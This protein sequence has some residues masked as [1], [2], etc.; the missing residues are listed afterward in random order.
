M[1][2]ERYGAFA[3]MLTGAKRRFTVGEADA[4][5]SPPHP[6]DRSIA[7]RSFAVSSIHGFSIELL[8]EEE[9]PEF[10]RLAFVVAG[11]SW[12]RD[13]SLY[14][15]NSERSHLERPLAATSS[16]SIC[17]RS[18]ET[19]I[20]LARGYQRNIGAMDDV[21]AVSAGRTASPFASQVPILCCWVSLRRPPPSGNSRRAGLV[22]RLLSV[23]PREESLSRFLP[24]LLQ[25]Q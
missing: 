4:D 14:R 18:A 7:D 8:Q 2:R 17:T 22:E 21:P 19:G 15:K 24:F 23:T 13:Y 9:A 5:S 25:G 20:G 6:A 3:S 12:H 11:R 10:Q 16:L 1:F